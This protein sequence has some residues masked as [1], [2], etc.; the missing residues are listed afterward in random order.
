MWKNIYPYSTSELK[1][2]NENYQKVSNGCSAN[3]DPTTCAAIIEIGIRKCPQPY[4]SSRAGQVVFADIRR[5]VSQIGKVNDKKTPKTINCFTATQVGRHSVLRHIELGR[6]NANNVINP[7]VVSGTSGPDATK[8]G[9]ASATNMK[10]CL[11][12]AR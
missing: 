8:H 11:I 6:I 5:I 2:I 3:I 10:Y 1:N 7:D 9:T 12:N 4:R